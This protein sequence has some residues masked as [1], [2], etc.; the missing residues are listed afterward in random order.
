[1]IRFAVLLACSVLLCDALLAA[2]GKPG[3]QVRNPSFVGNDIVINVY[4]QH[5]M[6]AAVVDPSRRFFILSDGQFK[7]DGLTFTKGKVLFNTK[8]AR[9]VRWENGVAYTQFVFSRPGKYQIIVADN[10]ETELEN[11]LSLSFFVKV[12]VTHRQDIQRGNLCSENKD[13]HHFP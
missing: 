11:T 13:A 1:M 4:P 6:K 3:E 9:G 8:K 10:L 2:G 7:C 12:R 5:L